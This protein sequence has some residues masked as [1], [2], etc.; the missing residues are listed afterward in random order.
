[1]VIF[2]ACQ[3]RLAMASVF[4]SICDFN[5]GHLHSP[6]IK[7]VH[8]V[9]GLPTSDQIYSNLLIS[10]DKICQCEQARQTSKKCSV[11]GH[12][13]PGFKTTR[14]SHFSVEMFTSLL[15]VGYSTW[16]NVHRWEDSHHLQ[17]GGSLA[18]LLI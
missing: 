17:S 10:S 8:P 3:I 18:S 14:L 7:S 15:A 12:P 13:R 6:P 5:Y 1:M 16:C 2:N 4:T 11:G 9:A